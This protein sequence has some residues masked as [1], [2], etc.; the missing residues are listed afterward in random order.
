MDLCREKVVIT[1]EMT[2]PSYSAPTCSRTLF[3]SGLHGSC[4][5]CAPGA[6]GGRQPQRYRTQDATHGTLLPEEL[7]VT[8]VLIKWDILRRFFR[9]FFMDNL[10]LALL[11]SPPQDAPQ[12]T[13][14]P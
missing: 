9:R 13:L 1:R 10:H 14:L 4:D 12:G 7:D 6:G 5:G 3:C 2:F 8:V 11:P